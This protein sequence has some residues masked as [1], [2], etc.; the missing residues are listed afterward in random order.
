MIHVCFGL[1]DKTGRYSKFT[2]TT[3]LSL[4]ENT[5]TPPPSVTVHI[6]HDNTLTDENRDK[7]NQIAGRY[8]QLI[9]FY[10]VE[11][12][13]ADRIAEFI[14]LMPS[15]KKSRLTVGALYRLLII[16]LLPTDV[17]KVIYLDSDIVVNMDINELWQIE[18]G[19]KIF[20]AVPEILSYQ[21]IDRMNGAF[22][23]CNDGF[24]KHEDY[25]NTGTL[26][27]NLELLRNEENTILEGL[28]FCAKNVRY[29][30]YGDQDILNYCFSTR[31]L[32]LPTTF[33][34][35]TLYARMAKE[36]AAEKIYHYAGG[37]FGYG[38]SLDVNDPFNRLWFD[39]FVK[40]PFFDADTIGRLYANMQQL[41]IGLK[42]AMANISA[43][44]SNKARAFFAEPNNVDA[45]KRVFSIRKD[46]EIIRAE[47]QQSVEKL[48]KAMK[49]SRGKKVFFIMLPFFPFDALTNA[50]FEFGKDF[51]NGLE[52]L[53][54]T[55]GMPL[56]S[57]DII[58]N[59]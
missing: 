56:N 45:I 33:N 54:E 30:G 25:F 1:Y 10:N 20:A 29:Q 50:G 9:K 35:F 52:F 51:V 37:N 24:V 2:G 46:E 16:R 21:T 13:C 53:S 8:G 26:A 5:S 47:N 19:D 44:V 40:T 42:N 49:K 48:L 34:R 15:I 59:M 27:I 31:T 28:Q 58:K 43:I 11:E 36:T 14:R 41:N 4:F 12:L 22:S 6:L 7:F 3:I 57:Y 39:Y 23:L 55:H 38:L 17:D 32:H 18:L